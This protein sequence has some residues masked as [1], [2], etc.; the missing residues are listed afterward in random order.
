VKEPQETANEDLPWVTRFRRKLPRKREKKINFRRRFWWC[1]WRYCLEPLKRFFFWIIYKIPILNRYLPDISGRP[2]VIQV[3]TSQSVAV[4]N[5]GTRYKGNGISTTKYGPI[6][7]IPL[8][9]YEQ[10][11]R[12]ANIWF[13]IVAAIQVANPI[14]HTHL[15]F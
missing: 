9:L 3:D 15:P 2:R 10:F 4:N 11:K 12:F 13:L 1:S 5:K 7:F 8:N 6:T 14:P